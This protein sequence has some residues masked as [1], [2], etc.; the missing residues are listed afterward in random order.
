M[1]R[2]KGSGK[3]S[4]VTLEKPK[5]TG[6]PLDFRYGPNWRSISEKFRL[7]CPTC[8][9]CLRRSAKLTHHVAYVDGKGNL[10]LD[11]VVLGLDVYT[12]CDGCHRIVH[13][14]K[15]YVVSPLGKQFNQNTSTIKQQLKVG[16]QLLMNE[17]K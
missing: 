13:T 4:K 14:G 6:Q 15:N 10:L 2:K 7:E 17:R 3:K 5:S 1:S 9:W 11:D 16:Y 8:C 12:L